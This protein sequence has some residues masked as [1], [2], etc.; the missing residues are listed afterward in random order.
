M[1]GGDKRDS[2]KWG[3][4]RPVSP[5]GK[6]AVEV[7]DFAAPSA[8]GRFQFF[9]LTDDFACG[10]AAAESLSDFEANWRTGGQ[11][12]VTFSA[13]L[14]GRVQAQAG[15][16]PEQERSPLQGWITRQGPYD[17]SFRVSGGQ[18][19]RMFTV[20][21]TPDYLLTLF[22]GRVPPALRALLEKDGAAALPAPVP[23]APQAVLA[24]AFDPATTGALR[25]MRA[26]AIALLSLANVLD[27][28]ADSDIGRSPENDDRQLRAARELLLED[29]GNPPTIAELAGMVGVS[30]WRLTRGFRRLFGVTPQRMLVVARMNAAQDMLR[31]GMIPLKVIAWRL[32]YTHVSNFI[33][34][35][36][37]LFGAPPRTHFSLGNGR[38]NTS[39]TPSDG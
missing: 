37:R 38:P 6:P 19:I 12:L 7:T 4:W 36:T 32:G 22:D 1:R 15:D 20:T 31:D 3:D 13:M 10:V 39:P 17:T 11:G 18:D 2:W 24:Q 21:T 23:F 26:E 30:P 28:L 14:A 29:L 5:A 33:A 34:A 16:L 9:T 35:Y 8:R 27:A 25:R